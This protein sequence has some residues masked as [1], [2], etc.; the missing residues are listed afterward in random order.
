MNQP[1]RN[2]KRLAT[3][4][5]GM[6]LATGVVTILSAAP[7]G[8]KSAQETL[9]E[10]QEL[11]IRECKLTDEQQKAIKEKF[12]LKM[13][14][15][16][17]WEKAN[18]EKLKAADEAAKTARQGTDEAAKKKAASDLKDLT[19]ARTQATAEADKAILAALTEEQQ[20]IWAGVQLA[21]TTLPRYKKANLTDDQTAKVK[22]ACL[23]AAKD[24]AASAGDDKKAKQGRSTIE[25]SLKWAIDNV[26]LTA[27]QR[28]TVTR[29]PAAK[30]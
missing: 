10:Q 26:I 28:E 4:F 8:P 1:T 14:A 9:Q 19:T 15:L 2:M 25:K 5:L 29:K 30:K 13:E 11:I 22:S 16:E 27:E 24:L 7:R 6:V 21:Q 3:I 20:V 18:A 23:I 17:T 12:K